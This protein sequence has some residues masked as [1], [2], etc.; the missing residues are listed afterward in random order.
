MACKGH[1]I[2]GLPY[3]E[4]EVDSAYRQAG[5]VAQ[6]GV[7]G[8]LRHNDFPYLDAV[9]TIAAF[10]TAEIYRLLEASQTQQGLDL[11]VAHVFVLRQLSDRQF[12]QEKLHSIQ[13]LVDAL[14]NLR[15]VFYSYF[16]DIT[17]QQYLDI[18]VF[19]L[20]FLKPDRQ[21]LAIPDGD[22]IISAAL[23]EEVFDN[24]ARNAIQE[25]AKG[26]HF[27]V[28]TKQNGKFAEIS[29]SDTGCGILPEHLAKLFIPFF[30]TK[31]R[32]TGLG[33]SIVHGIVKNHGGELK[34]KSQVGKGST[35]TL[36]LP[37]KEEKKNDPNSRG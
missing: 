7:D 22:R 19:E 21:H 6:I 1:N 16:D 18:A 29:F 34:V 12:L 15:D 30:T 4:E 24:L 11:A 3:G 5:I 37:L 13:L 27:M 26:G 20:P 33:L 9:D 36:S 17:P 8:S 35:F 28:E 32:G 2:V 31:S 25:M 14:A 23:L 10:A